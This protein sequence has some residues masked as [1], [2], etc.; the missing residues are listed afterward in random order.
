MLI[1]GGL[2]S[3]TSKLYSAGCDRDRTNNVAL[4]AAA[5]VGRSNGPEAT[6]QRR[7][8]IEL[9]SLC[10]PL[11]YTRPTAAVSSPDRIG[12]GPAFVAK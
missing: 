9:P 3:V 4:P 6:M 12:R 7:V 2:Y 10:M 11:N 8:R 5:D 1:T